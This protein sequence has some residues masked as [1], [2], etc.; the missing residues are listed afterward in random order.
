MH[1][2]ILLMISVTF[3][4]LAFYWETTTAWAGMLSLDRAVAMFPYFLLGAAVG[5]KGVATIVAQRSRAVSL[6]LFF[7]LCSYISAAPLLWNLY[8]IEFV[9]PKLFLV[10]APQFMSKGLLA[11]GGGICALGWIPTQQVPIITTIGK[12]SLYTYIL[13]LFVLKELH[14]LIQQ[15]EWDNDVEMSV[16]LG[17]SPLVV[18]LLGSP[19]AVFCFWPLLNPVWLRVLY[20]LPS[21]VQ[22]NKHDHRIAVTS[23][24]IEQLTD[25]QSLEPVNVNG[26]NLSPNLDAP[27]PGYQTSFP[28]FV[29]SHALRIAV[30]GCCVY[31]ILFD[32][33]GSFIFQNM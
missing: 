14:I 23:T 3:A 32:E 2:G 28:L 17:V 8:R 5:T 7:A 6:G 16:L 31:M 33:S 4:I 21:A 19:F 1:I 9:S 20:L 10:S 24:I 22:W 18:C 30:W 15:A 11:L 25:W 29:I 26:A 13:H 27:L 12:N